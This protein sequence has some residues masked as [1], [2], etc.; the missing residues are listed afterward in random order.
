[1]IEGFSVVRGDRMLHAQLLLGIVGAA[2]TIRAGGDRPCLR[3]SLGHG[4]SA[5]G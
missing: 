4:A 2:Y 5:V 3:G 1:M